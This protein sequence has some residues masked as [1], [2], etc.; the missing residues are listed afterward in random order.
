MASLLGQFFNNIRG[1][2]EDIASKGL[3]YILRE[4]TSAKDVVN[5]I[6]KN[7]TGLHFGNIRYITQ[8]VGKN[9]ER[10]DISGIDDAGV[11]KIIIETKFWSSLTNNQPVEYLKRLDEESVLI[12]ISPKLR[13]ASLMSEIKIKLRDSD[14]PYDTSDALIE[15][16][17]Q[18]YIFIVDWNTVLDAI[19][20][21]L[22]QNGESMLVSDIDQIIG[23]CQ[24]IDSNR[25]LP[26][27]D[28]DLSPSVARRISSYYA[29]LD[30]VVDKLKVKI[31]ISTKR[32]NATG[33]RFGYTRYFKVKD[34]SF[35]LELH[36]LL[37]Q[38]IADTPFW[39]TVK[40]DWKPQSVDFINKLKRI[41]L[42]TNIDLHRNNENDSF[43]FALKP[44][45]DEIEGIVIEGLVEKIIGIIKGL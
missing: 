44:E 17:G 27:Q 45:T 13:E 16:E 15:V 9:K 33:Q 26:I 4:S 18:K 40:E 35:S 29:L 5:K 1:S 10:P 7:N 6:I 11:E 32:L 22:A 39:L 24:I 12:F 20:Q 19:R 43:C 2:Q 36:F 30:K 42:E 14:I 37:W 41:S 34:Y 28:S 38:N 21:S 31:D 23:F 8:S 3:T 25:F